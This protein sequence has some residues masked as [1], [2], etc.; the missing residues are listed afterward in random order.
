[1]PNRD[2][3]ARVCALH[4][5]SPLYYRPGDNSNS[6]QPTKNITTPLSKYYN[7]HD[8]KNVKLGSQ[9]NTASLPHYIKL[10]HVELKGTREIL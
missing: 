9:K 4:S 1:M 5:P 3:S 7:T 6:C 2:H 10:F 8:Y